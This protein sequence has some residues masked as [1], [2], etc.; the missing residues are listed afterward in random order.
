MVGRDA[1][2]NDL[3]A[4]LRVPP[5]GLGGAKHGR[6]T[7]RSSVREVSARAWPMRSF[8]GAGQQVTFVGRG[9]AAGEG[10]DTPLQILSG[11]IDQPIGV[12]GEQGARLERDLDGRA[13]GVRVE[14]RRARAA[15]SASLPGRRHGA[16]AGRMTCGGQAD[17]VAGE[18]D[19]GVHA[20]GEPPGSG[21]LF[22]GAPAPART[23]V[24]TRHMRAATFTLWPWT[25]P[26]TAA[27][28]ASSI[29]IKCRKP[30]LMSS[31]CAAGR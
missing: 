3:R 11:N 10:R 8:A 9:D 12:R 27:A 31:P 21:S 22:G 13:R 25:S 7:A 2:S 14:Q 15:G 4:R 18:V 6:S 1:D 26:M 23:V 16:A 28:V 17:G 24:R 19:M 20:A 5:P 30:P 29:R